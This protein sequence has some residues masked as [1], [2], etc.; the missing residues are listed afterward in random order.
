M[1]TT[2]SAQE[3]WRSK[4]LQ[5]S[6]SRMR[7]T[8][9]RRTLAACTLLVCLVCWP[10][11]G[12][13][14]RDAGRAPNALRPPTLDEALAGRPSDQ[15]LAVELETDLGPVHCE[16]DPRAAPNAVALFVGLATGRASF[17]DGVSHTIVRRPYYRDM[18]FNRAIAGVLLQSGDRIGD[19]SG[20]PGYRIALERAAN[21]RQRLSVPGALVLAR[22]TLPPGR[23]D[24]D[25]P[26]PGQVLGSQFALLLQ[27]MPH[28]AGQVG[29]LGHCSDLERARMIADD[30]ASG[31]APHRLLD[32][33]VP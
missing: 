26:L 25:P 33:H 3:R 20:N 9:P 27:P 6:R 24:P 7:Q 13:R 1:P 23:Q 5:H 12:A 31:R 17:L 11:C 16:L 19:T 29:V 22:Y 15:L 4:W 21:D 30:L 10:A 14:N 32:V 2:P 8:V 18:T 28:L